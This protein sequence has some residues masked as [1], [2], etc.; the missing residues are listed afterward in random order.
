MAHHVPAEEFDRGVL[1]LGRQF[2]QSGGVGRLRQRAALRQIGRLPHP[3]AKGQPTACDERKELRHG[4]GAILR[5][6]Q[7]IG[8]RVL[9][10]EIGRLAQQAR[11]RMGARQGR[12]R[13][14]Q[15]LNL[16]IRVTD[17]QPAAVLLQHVDAGPAVGGVDH[18]VHGAVWRQHLAQGAQPAVRV[19]QVVQHAGADDLVEAA[20]QLAHPLDRQLIDLQIGQ[21]VLAA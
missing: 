16:L 14:R 10:L 12:E 2:G 6:E 1:L 20:A 8:Q 4:V 7:R 11:Q 13:D 9:A 15:I 3:A 5:V 18:Q 17:A 19:G 21:V